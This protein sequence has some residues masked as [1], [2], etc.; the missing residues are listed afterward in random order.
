MNQHTKSDKAQNRAAAVDLG[1]DTRVAFIQSCWH[2]D[3]VDRGRDSFLDAMAGHGVP[4]T[5]ID[6]FEVPG[7]FEIPLLAKK[8]AKL[9]RYE[10]I[11]AC[12]LVVDGGIY[13]HEFVASAVIDALM[14]IQLE[15]EVPVLSAVLTPQHFHEHD[16]HRRFFSDHFLVKG[17]EAAN[18]CARTIA[19]MRGLKT[20]TPA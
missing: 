10:A 19:N 3:I 12:G 20:L 8:L 16:E 11:V 9:G 4:R 14:S 7:A 13:R 18:A 6:L 1:K 2:D 17:K 15:T 5:S